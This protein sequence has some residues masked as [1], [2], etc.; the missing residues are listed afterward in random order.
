LRPCGKGVSQLELDIILKDGTVVDPVLKKEINADVGISDGKVCYVGKSDLHAKKQLN[1][2]RMLV[3]PGFIDS[4]MHFEHLE[5][6]DPYTVLRA[7]LCQGVTTAFSGHCG[8][9]H[10]IDRYREFFEKKP[11]LNMGFFIG[12]T[13]LRYAV[14]VKDRYSAIEGKK[15]SQMEKLLRENLEKGAWGLS[16]GLEY[17]PGTTWDEMLR[18][19]FIVSEFKDRIISVHIRY[20]GKRSIEAVKEAINLARESGVRVQIS[21]L[22]SM[23]AFGCSRE[24]LEMIDAANQ[25][26]V[27]VTF[28]VYPYDAFAAR[29]GSA[30]FDP[31]FEERWGKGLDALEIATGKFRGEKLT[32]ELLEKARKEDPDAYV[33]AHV[34]SAEE[35]NECLL[36]P[37]SAIA[38][39][40][41]LRGSEGHPRAAGTFPRGIKIL[42]D[43][44]LSW[45]EAIAHVTTRPSEMLNYEGGTI[46][47]GAPANIA[48]IDP[49][50]FTDQAT[51]NNPL[52]KP[53]GVKWVIV[54]GRIAVEDG[55]VVDVN[56]GKMLLR[57]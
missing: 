37:K 52:E 22:G 55:E 57:S 21:H 39:D 24:S 33:I 26:G 30:V 45:S 2:K 32:Q 23:T 56:C 18:L 36:H 20:D 53:Q 9:G 48:V 49:G 43:A 7:L 42:R 5:I 8:E 1:A 4:H 40:A 10:F 6:G 44:G 41:V 11:V 15:I 14:G 28:D 13:K 38:S 17:V 35:V 16:F 50:S 34:M 27:D 31:G 29:A 19:A 3:V 46:Q 54:N 51:F 25:E 47:V 12:A